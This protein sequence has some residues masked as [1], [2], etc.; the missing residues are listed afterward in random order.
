MPRAQ[1][2]LED[3]QGGSGGVVARGGQP[4]AQAGLDEV[5]GHEHHIG[6]LEALLG[7]G[8]DKFPDLY[9]TLTT[10]RNRKWLPRISG[11]LQEKQDYLVVVGA[12]H[13]IGRGGVVELLTRQGFTPVQQ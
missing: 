7:E 4:V 12:M 3:R 9:R 13:L 2:A 1:H 10:D 8:L 11:L 5:G 6:G